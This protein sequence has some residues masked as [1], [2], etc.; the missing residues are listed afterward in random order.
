[1]WRISPPCAIKQKCL[2]GLSDESLQKKLF[3]TASIKSVLVNSGAGFTDQYLSC[4]LLAQGVRIRIFDNFNP[5][6]H[7]RS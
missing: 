4:V 5:Q 3:M 6:I 7:S 2:A 1:M